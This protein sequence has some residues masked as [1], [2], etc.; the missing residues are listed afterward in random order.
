[1]QRDVDLKSFLCYIK[2]REEKGV[3][4]ERQLWQLV[5]PHFPGHVCRIENVAEPGMPD[6]NGCYEALEYWV[7]LKESKTLK[8]MS[9]PQSLLRPS[10]NAWHSIRTRNKGAIFVLVRYKKTIHLTL[11]ALDSH[12]DRVYDTVG[13]YSYPIDW[14]WFTSDMRSALCRRST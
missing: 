11:A 14:G 4:T 10:Q 7:E 6:I 3:G 13:W 2:G 8:Q 1:V 12:G 5:K 9:E